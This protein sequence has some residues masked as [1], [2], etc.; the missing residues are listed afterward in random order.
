[1]TLS[2]IGAATY[3]LQEW[4]GQLTIWFESQSIRLLGEIP[5][6]AMEVEEIGQALRAAGQMRVRKPMWPHTLAVYMAAIAAR[7]DE[8]S[9]QAD[10]LASPATGLVPQG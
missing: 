3:C 10:L 1:M 7:N 5:L 4:E 2:P 6:S 8:R 9:S